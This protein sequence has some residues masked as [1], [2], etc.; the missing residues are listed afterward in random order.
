MPVYEYKALNRK[1]K[2]LR[3]LITADGPAAARLK[4]S[5]EM[6]FPTMVREVQGGEGKTSLSFLP[7]LRSIKSL[8]VTMALR[9]LATLLS[10]GLQ[11][12]DSL[13]GVIEQTEHRRLKKVLI[14][15]REKVVEGMSL[16]GAMAKHPSTFNPIFVNMIKAGETG[17]AL[18]VI[19]LRLADF[20]EKRMKLKKRVEAALA[21]PLFLLLLSSMIL[22]FL[23]S[24]VMPKVVGIFQGM[25][26]TLP[27][28]TLLLIHATSFM[29]SYWWLVTAGLFSCAVLFSLWTRTDSGRLI[30]D[31]VRLRTPLV[32]KLHHKAVIARFTRTLSTLLKS[33]VI[34]VEALEIARLSMGNRIMEDAVLEAGRLVNQGEEF[35]VLLKRSKRFPP[36]VVQLVTAGEKGGELDEMLGKAAEV[37]EE[38]VETAITSLTSLLEPVVIL[39][40]GGMVGFIVMAVLL[41]IFDMTTSIR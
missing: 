28:S 38:D 36:L 1:G 22:I 40:M 24:F 25:K 11:L 7:P 23:L 33:G 35:G 16:S 31:R 12:V 39:F 14:Q 26:L 13:N 21:Y 19:L 37:Y 3:G 29:K 4:L 34:L 17:G 9:Q 20:S 2:S 8:E 10:S 30:W 5:Q 41:P 15:I 32:G 6:I 18:D 27:W